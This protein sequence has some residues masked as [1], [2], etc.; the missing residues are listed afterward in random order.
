M[1]VTQAQ[2]DKVT[3]AITPLYSDPDFATVTD[4]NVAVTQTAP[5]TEPVVTTDQIDVVKS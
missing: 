2:I 1:S 4:M 3:A 5:P